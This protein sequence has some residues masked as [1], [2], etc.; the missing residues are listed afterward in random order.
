MQ[1][2]FDRVEEETCASVSQRYGVNGSLLKKIYAKISLREILVQTLK[3]SLNRKDG[4]CREDC[5]DKMYREL[6]DFDNKSLAVFE[7]LQAIDFEIKGV[8][9][10]IE[11]RIE[12]KSDDKIAKLPNSAVSKQSQEKI[13]R[14]AS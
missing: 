10:Q 2:L 4:D 8:F 14:Y 11:Y 1:N 12:A 6:R 7:M 5:M 3:S 13:L 9:R